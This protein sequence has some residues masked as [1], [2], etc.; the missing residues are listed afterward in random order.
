MR[1][2]L[3][4]A[5]V[6]AL[7]L[8]GLVTSASAG[9]SSIKSIS[10]NKQSV[11]TGSLDPDKTDAKATLRIKVKDSDGVY[12]VLAIILNPR[13]KGGPASSLLELELTSGSSEN[14]T[15]TAVARNFHPQNAGTWIVSKVYVVDY[16]GRSLTKENKKSGLGGEDAKLKVTNGERSVPRVSVSVINKSSETCKTKDVATC[17]QIPYEISVRAKTKNN[18]PLSDAKV[19]LVVCYD[20]EYEECTMRHLGRTDSK[21]KLKKKFYPSVFLNSDIKPDWSDYELLSSSDFVAY[22][23]V[24]PTRK[25]T[26]AVQKS[27]VFYLDNK[28][29]EDQHWYPDD[30]DWIED[31]EPTKPRTC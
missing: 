1:R 10:W 15:W 17:V 31:D 9:S 30:Y 20:T 7:L 25:T 12:G 28:F 27:S 14:G 19:R 5:V 2:I 29:C 26:Y 3:S 16:A 21:G 22:I 4:V 8:S 18:L 24:L 11:N 23:S 6:T 13:A